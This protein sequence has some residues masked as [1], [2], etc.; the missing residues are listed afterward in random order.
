MQ[1]HLDYSVLTHQPIWGCRHE[2]SSLQENTA[3]ASYKA[4][5][6]SS[7]KEI[8]RIHFLKNI[9]VC[10]VRGEKWLHWE[11]S[12]LTRRVKVKQDQ[13]RNCILQHNKTIANIEHIHQYHLFLSWGTCSTFSSMF[14]L[15]FD[16]LL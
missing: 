1:L 11:I 12:Q 7:P 4:I 9:S 5:G 8:E 13:L 2:L 10:Q 6:K 3:V 16:S 14:M 15:I